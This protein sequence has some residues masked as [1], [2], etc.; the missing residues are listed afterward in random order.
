M[1]KLSFYLAFASA[2]SFTLYGRGGKI[3]GRTSHN[4]FLRKQAIRLPDNGALRAEWI[5][6]IYSACDV[7]TLPVPFLLH[8]DD[9]RPESE[10][11]SHADLDKWDELSE[12]AGEVAAG[13]DS[14]PLVI[15]AIVANIKER[16]TSYGRLSRAQLLDFI[17][18]SEQNLE[19]ALDSIP[20]EFAIDE[21]GFVD[22]IQKPAKKKPAKKKGK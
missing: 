18:C 10:R 2:S 22:L 5:Q 3:L 12:L 21:L 13:S 7:T 19:R 14:D 1:S 4:K 8:E 9:S 15:Q 11:Y 20:S 17:E 16:I 6:Q